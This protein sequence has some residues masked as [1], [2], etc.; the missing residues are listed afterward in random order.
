MENLLQV[1]L[2]LIMAGVIYVF[3]IRSNETQAEHSQDDE[4]NNEDEDEDEYMN[5]LGS[6]PR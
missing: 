6:R 1:I 2:L 4:A 3:F 5:I